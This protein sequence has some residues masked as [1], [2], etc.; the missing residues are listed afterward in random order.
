VIVAEQLSRII[1]SKIYAKRSETDTSYTRP[2]TA[3]KCNQ[4]N[5]LPEKILVNHFGNWLSVSD[6]F[7]PTV[8]QKRPRKGGD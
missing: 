5:G 2:V 3:T 8:S 6:L 4:T 7:G 1:D